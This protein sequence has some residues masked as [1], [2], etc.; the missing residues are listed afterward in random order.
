MSREKP[1]VLAVG[2]LPP[3]FNGMSV[4]FK[5]LCQ[6]T[7]NDDVNLVVLDIADNRDIASIGKLDVVNIF[8][9]F[10]HGYQFLRL[11]VKQK[12]D[13]VYMPIAQGVLG[14]LRDCLFLIPSRL[15]NL[16][17]IVHLHGSE[18]Q[19]F[20][21][22]SMWPMRKLIK[23]SLA[24]AKKA[25]VLGNALKGEFDGIL[26]SEKVAVIPNG[27]IIQHSV[28]TVKSPKDENINVTYLGALKR[29][30]GYQE[31]IYAIPD[32]VSE[33]N[34]M[35]FYLAGEVCDF[36]N[37]KEVTDFIKENR[38]EK[39][40]TFSGVVEGEDKYRLLEKADI[41]CFPPIEPEGQPL[42][43]LEAMACGLPVISTEFGAIPDI[44]KNGENGFVISPG[45]RQQLVKKITELANSFEKRQEM[46]KA[47]KRMY[48]NHFTREKWTENLKALFLK[49]F[50][51]ESESRCT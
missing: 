2:A 42:V 18:F 1:K 13:I 15:L 17:V 3:P 41:F 51:N 23:Y 20:Y 14:Y 25:I 28:K 29:R 36:E 43:I 12:P 16:P 46:G 4:V 5:N 11:L 7:L 38:L 35:H 32:I 49:V 24:K 31:I 30:K 8:L 19:S 9:A 48:E 47:S 34:N 44:V 39:Y 40:I 33:V 21:K 6:S 10:L 37:Y 22:K 50:T 27:I 26:S 45:N